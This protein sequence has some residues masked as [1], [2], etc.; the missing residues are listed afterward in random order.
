M[1]IEDIPAGPTP[2]RI[3]SLRAHLPDS[4]VLDRDALA[5]RD[6]GWDAGNLNAFALVRPG[7]VAEVIELVSW[8]RAQRCAFVPQGGRTG[9][10]GGSITTPDQLI[11]DLGALDTI[12]EIDPA[13]GI[14]VVQAG[15]TLTAL[16]EA[17]AAFGLHPGLDLAARGSATIGGLIA[18]NAGGITAFRTGVM[19]HR[20][21]GL[22][23]VL[24]DGRL[25]DDMTRVLKTSAGYDVKQLLIGAEGT[26]GIVTRAV[27]RLDPLPNGRATALLGT[28]GAAQAL[29]I[30]RRLRAGS[31]PLLAAEIMWSGF[32]AA[33]S[34]A[35]G[36]DPTQLPLRS[37]CLLLVEL[38]AASFEAARSALEDA[39]AALAETEPDLDG[40]VSASMAQ[41]AQLWRLREDTD[42]L[43]RLHPQAPSYDISLPARAFDAYAARLR[44]ALKAIGPAIEPYLFGHLA[45]GNLHI[46]LNRPG[47][48]QPDVQAAVE[49]AIYGELRGLGGSFS[50]EHGI[51]SKR[52]AALQRHADPVKLALMAELKRLFDPDNLCNPGKVV[53]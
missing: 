17:A 29:D 1:R 19:R 39:L 46:V 25:V 43:Y 32:A 2:D 47:P 3:A 9:L 11:C 22:E 38:G 36:L 24:P 37:P 8:C 49:A 14:A 50:A 18:T 13:S 28:T 7:S 21:L 45:D 30:V 48:L 15:V 52:I 42:V 51:G 16:Q 31:A 33:T 35:L 23:A 6:P 4:Q 41:S 40:I 34:A 5:A 20:V 44:P 53:A 10:V 26:L 12:E 27:I